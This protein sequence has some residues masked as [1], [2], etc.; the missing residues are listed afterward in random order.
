MKTDFK[1]SMKE[2]YAP[3]SKEFTLVDVPK[4]SFLM[5]DGK[6]DP[7][8]APEYTEALQTLYPVAYKAKFIAKNTLDKDYVV[9]SLEGLWWAEDMASYTENYDRSKWLWTMMIMQPDW[10]TSAIVDEARNLAAKKCSGECLEKLRFES[11]SEGQALQ[12]LHIG[13]YADEAPTLARLHDE[14]MPDGGYDY[15]GKHHEI[16]LSDPRRVAPE[17]LKTI[18][19]QPV[20]MKA[21]K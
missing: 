17:K 20:K 1:K 12:C 19:R 14:I 3:K 8:S 5:I 16:Y 4:M 13:S 2:L 6:G 10:I 18:L 15:N 7:G 9:P 21:S 11:F